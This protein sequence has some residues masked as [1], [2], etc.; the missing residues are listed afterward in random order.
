M[1]PTKKRI[2]VLDYLRGFALLGIIFANIV[3]IIHVT[4]HTGNVDIVYLSLI[5][6]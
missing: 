3:S 6:I 2:E 1:E 4:E 5:H